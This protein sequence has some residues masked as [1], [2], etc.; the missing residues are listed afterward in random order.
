MRNLYL[1]DLL[2]REG[3]EISRQ[4]VSLQHD[5]SF[6]DIYVCS[7]Q[8]RQRNVAF[9]VY[10]NAWRML[11]HVQGVPYVGKVGLRD[12]NLNLSIRGS[13]HRT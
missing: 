4:L 2:G 3:A 8:S 6:I 9:I 12:M 13:R 11:Q 5:L 7:S 10:G 1:R